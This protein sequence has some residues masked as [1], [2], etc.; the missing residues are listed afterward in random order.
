M[1]AI[2]LLSVSPIE[3]GLPQIAGFRR[4]VADAGLVE[5]ETVA[6]EYRSAYSDLSRLPALASELAGRHVAVIATTG[7]PAAALAAKAATSTLPIVF[8][9]GGDPVEQG[10]VASLARSG[11]NVTG[12]ARM[13]VALEPKRLELLHELL[14]KTGKIAFLVN[15]SNPLAAAQLREL[16]APARALGLSVLPLRAS[17]GNE[18]DQAFASM[19]R[20]GATAMLV[21]NDS[22]FESRRV[23][24]AM[25]SDIYSVPIVATS[26]AMVAAGGLMSYGANLAD[27]YRQVG[28]YAGRIVNGE[29]PAELP[30]LQPTRFELVINL[31]TA[32]ALGIDVPPSLRARADEVIE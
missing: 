27:T 10:F 28:V 31:R 21:A 15:P 26:R 20:E 22:F 5:G 17:R 11:G 6:I 13:S 24:V 19:A 8:Q 1:P 29:S 23:H 2:G 3:P 14:P 18:L 16:E 32:K 12:I 4:G 25:L 9:I 30:V 7:G